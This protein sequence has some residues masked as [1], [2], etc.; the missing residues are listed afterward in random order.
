[1]R[2]IL[3]AR[4]VLIAALLLLIT[5]FSFSQSSFTVSGKINDDSGRPVEGVTITEKGTKNAT[6]TKSDGSFQLT[7]SSGTAV[8]V[9]SHIAYEPQELTLSNNASVSISLRPLSTTMQDVV[10]VGYG[11]K[12]KSDVTGAISSVNTEEM[13]KIPVAN[14]SQALQGRIPGLV[15]TPSSYRPGSSSTIR[16]RGTRSLTANNNPLYVVDGIPLDIS[17]TIDDINPLDIESIDVMKD[18]SATAIYGSRGANGVIQIT[19]KKGKTGK[20][21]VEYSGSTSFDNI[22]VPLEVFS[23][24]EW[25]QLKRD[26]YIASRSYNNSLLA[27]NPTKL[28]FPDPKADSALF[29]ARGDIY[30]WRSVAQGYTWIDESRLIAAKRATT[31]EEKALMQNLGFAVLDSVAMYDPSRVGSYDWQKQ[32]LRTGITQSH[33]ISLT[34]GSDKFRS[35][36]SAGYFNQRGI[37]YGQD[38]KRYTFTVSTDFKPNKIINV[39]GNISYS[40]AIQNVGT[41]L[42]TSASYMLP[43]AQP[44]DST[45]KLIFNPGNDANIVNPLNDP[46]TIINE[47]RINRLLANAY[48]DVQLYKG[49]KYR[50]AFGGDMRNER[51]GRFNGSISSARVGGPANASFVVRARFNWTLQNML[52]YDVKLG[53][54]HNIS[55]LAAQE[56]V[57]SRFEGDSMGAENLSYESQRWYSLQNNS[58]ASV[59]GLGVFEQIQLAS[60]LGR[61]NYGFRD[62]YLLTAS[63]RND[64]SSVLADGHKG[65]LF[66][67]AA[68]AWRVDRESFMT[69]INWV[70]MLKLRVGYG[71]VGN[72]SIGPYQTAGT[73]ARSLYNWGSAPAAGYNPATLPLPDLTWEKTKT[74]N[75]AVDFGF[76]KNRITGTID[77]YESN[78]NQIQNKALPAAS[79]FSRVLVN[80]GNVR[81]RG[82]ELTLSTINIDRQDGLRWTTD[83]I[84]S[85]NKQE[86]TY[87]ASNYSNDVGNQWFVGHPTQIFYDWKLMGMFQYTDTMKGGILYEWFW[88]K[89]GNK[90]NAQFQP[91]RA[92]VMDVN[93]D[94]TITDADKVILGSFNPKWT[95]SFSTTFSWK[96]FDLSV[97][98]Y[99][100]FGSMIREIRPSLNARYQSFKVNYWTPTNPSNEYAQANNTVDIQQY[101]Q[102]MS[103][104]SGD[105]VKVRNI[106]LAYHIPASA[107]NRI[108]LSNAVVS[109]SVLNPFLFSKYKTADVETVPYKSSYPTSDNSGPNVNSYSFRSFV[110]G[111]RFG[112]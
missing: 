80:M 76:F 33:N 8:L 61:I 101:F 99:G 112:L 49:L 64:N 42:Y 100:Q 91:G 73:L 30:T 97:F 98:V 9:L 56:L 106:A 46:N 67:S 96:G 31:A 95:G 108:K 54:D 93:G 79:G 45:G 2:K 50:I 105:F 53:T 86:I 16:I 102:S 23:A 77:V 35:A 63:L 62:K 59:T 52:T 37:E 66:P 65:E 74:K 43:I 20:I 81:N 28:Y 40:N 26:G 85:R 3:L 51:Q 69:G 103:F 84:I 22:L 75:I 6:A 55:L 104:R 88:K 29:R 44:Y 60:F 21:S 47:L 41:S 87:L 83:F 94:T 78:S 18:A 90:T 109:F 72:S 107:L 39:G 36:F 38:Y 10:V 25:A 89:P 15:S 5:A 7:V 57:K 1:M 24:S 19:T 71:A 110:V 13:R 27:T 68:I 32:A 82:V 92:Y 58:L 11:T 12:R 111:V 17:N 34:G 4:S 14:L 48:V 70:S